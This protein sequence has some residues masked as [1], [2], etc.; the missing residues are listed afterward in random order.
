M[1]RKQQK[2][3]EYEIQRER[4]I[5]KNFSQHLPFGHI[6]LMF[7]LTLV[8]KRAW[9]YLTSY[10]NFGKIM[11]IKKCNIIIQS[12]KTEKKPYFLEKM[13][14]LRNMAVNTLLPW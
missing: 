11:L 13:Q 1:L 6:K 2:P 5:L 7:F 12:V 9:I 4:I 14:I 3:A 8:T 10:Y